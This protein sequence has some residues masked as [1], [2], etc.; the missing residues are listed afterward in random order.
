MTLSPVRPTATKTSITTRRPDSAALYDDAAPKMSTDRLAM[1]QA[2]GV[3]VWLSREQV[4]SENA[5][6]DQRHIAVSAEIPP[7]EVPAQSNSNDVSTLGWSALQA[8][9]SRCQT[10][11][12]HRGRTQTVFGTGDQNASW[13]IIGEA[14]GAE[15]DRQGEPFVGRA[16]QLLNAMLLAAGFKRREVYIANIVKC[17]PPDNRDPRPEEALSCSG[18]LN[19][20]IELVRPKLII[21]VG[22][23]AA[24]KLLQ[25]DTP[26]GKLRGKLHQYGSEPGVP[27]VVTYHPAYLLRSPKQKRKVWQDLL[28]ALEQTQA[29]Q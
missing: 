5:G 28:F 22:A 9:V 16:G 18:Y 26:V 29:A 25:S 23:V 27:V 6:T 10:C 19:R 13:M 3:R 24:Q 7:P 17:R 20:Q 14:P 2:M 1:L 21:A 8:R 15:E 12:L 4:E 11:D